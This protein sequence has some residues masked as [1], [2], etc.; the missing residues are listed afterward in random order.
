MLRLERVVVVFVLVD[1]VPIRKLI[2]IAGADSVDF[3]RCARK[4]GRGFEALM[5]DLPRSDLVGDL[6]RRR[7]FSATAG[8]G[9]QSTLKFAVIGT[10]SC[11]NVEEDME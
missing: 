9:H 1:S 10:V 3:V 7:S 2:V 5:G 11:G 8:R 4:W 6:R